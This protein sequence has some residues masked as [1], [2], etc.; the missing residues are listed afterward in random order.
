[1]YSIKKDRSIKKDFF[2]G[3]MSTSNSLENEYLKVF[4]IILQQYSEYHYIILIY[5]YYIGIAYR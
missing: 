5:T 2:Q 3:K 4:G 1:L